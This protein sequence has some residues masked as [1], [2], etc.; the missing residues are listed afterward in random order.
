MSIT[1]P[2]T[3][4]VAP[5]G[6]LCTTDLRSTQRTSP[7]GRTTR[8]SSGSILSVCS[9]V[10]TERSIASRSSSWMTGQTFWDASAQVG[11]QPRISVSSGE[12]QKVWF[13][14]SV[15]NTPACADSRARDRRSAFSCASRRIQFIASSWRLRVSMSMTRP[16]SLATEPSARRCSL[17]CTWI[18]R[19]APSGRRMRVSNASQGGSGP[20]PTRARTRSASSECTIGQA[21][22]QASWKLIGRPIRV[23]NSGEH[24]K[25]RVS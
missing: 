7:S 5:E 14:K 6:S 9:A 1:T 23:S 17:T 18:Q 8:V 3:L 16:V 19:T 15:S 20:D 10:S 22:P 13:W 4:E 2:T 21:G 11:V 12:H 25:A 24:Q